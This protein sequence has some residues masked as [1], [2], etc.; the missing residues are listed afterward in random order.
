M[1]IKF[2]NSEGYTLVELLVMVAVIGLG[3]SILVVFLGSL[4]IKSTSI[5][6]LNDTRRLSDIS[7]I[8]TGLDLFYSQAGGYPDTKLWQAGQTV[9][10]N[11]NS[12]FIVPHDPTLTSVFY[13]YRSRGTVSDSPNCAG[14]KVWSDYS[15]QFAIET[16]SYLGEPGRYCLISSKGIS[17]GPCPTN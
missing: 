1:K 16:K 11:A 10:C 3:I 17:P 5:Q 2:Y 6:T 12:I 14:S 15:V 13:I 9:A 8:T 4:R 7:Q